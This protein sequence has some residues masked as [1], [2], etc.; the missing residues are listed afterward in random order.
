MNATIDHVLYVWLQ[1]DPYRAPEV[2]VMAAPPMELTQFRD[3]HVDT[4]RGY[5]IIRVDRAY[6]TPTE[7][8]QQYDVTFVPVEAEGTSEIGRGSALPAQSLSGMSLTTIKGIGK[9]Y[10]DL[11]HQKANIDSVQTL[12]AAGATPQGRNQLTSQTGIGPTLILKWAQ[13][14]DLMRIEG[15]GSDYSQLL[16]ESGVTSV[17][18]LAAQKPKTLLKRLTKVIETQSAMRRL[19]QIEQIADWIRQASQLEP[20]VIL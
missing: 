5:L 14:A 3:H 11:L 20:V 13:L 9:R 4:S 6:D 7:A 15:M 19:P 8:G 2:R 12:L 17:P 16:W 18:R 10:A 1:G